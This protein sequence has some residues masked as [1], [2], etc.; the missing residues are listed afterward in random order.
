[1]STKL[2][3][4]ELSSGRVEFVSDPPQERRS[5]PPLCDHNPGSANQPAREPQGLRAP[6]IALTLGTLEISRS[7]PEK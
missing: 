5:A 4:V 2:P 7:L 1:M 6:I 3:M